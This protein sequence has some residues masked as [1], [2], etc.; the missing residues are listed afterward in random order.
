ML[1]ISSINI[2][3]LEESCITDSRP[4]IAFALES[5]REGES[6]K[7]ATISCEGW[8]LETSDQVNNHYGGSFE[9]FSTYTVQVVATGQSGD[10][11]EKTST[12]QTGRLDTPWQAKWITDGAYAI[13]DKQS[14]V[15]MVFR[16]CFAVGA[17]VRRARLFTTALG[18]Y[19]LCLN[20]SKVGQ[21]YF[22]PGLTSYE[23]QIQYQIYDVTKQ[24]LVSN[25]L[26]ATVAGGWAVGSFTYNRKNKISADRQALLLE[27][28]IEY[29]N[30][31]Q[32]IISTD[33]SWQVTQEGPYRIAEWY[34]GETFD[35]RIDL[36]QVE[37]KSASVTYPRGNP[38][39]IA[40]YGCPV[41]VQQVM[42]PVAH[43]KA[44]SGEWVYDFGQNFAGVISAK[45]RAQD[46]Q[47]L[48]F[49]HAEVLVNDELFIKSLRTAKATATYICKNGAQSY[50]PRLTY[51]GFRYVG[52]SGIKPEYIELEAFALHSELEETGSFE[53]SN[54]LINQLQSNI[55]WGGKSNFVD[56]PTDCPQR[57][58]RQG[59]TGDIAVFAQTACYN[60][61]MSRFFTKWLLD[62]Q[63]EQ[64]KGGGIPM[65]IPKAGDNWPV[66]ASACWG[67]SCVLVPWAEY[68]ARGDKSLLE[69]QY[70]VI[71]KFLK[72][73]KWW[74]SFMS[75]TPS[76]RYIWRWPFQYGDWCAPE[77]KVQQW[78]KR[79]KWIATPYFANSCAIAAQIADLLG[80]TEDA[81]YYRALQEKIIKA[82]RKVFTNGKGKLKKEFQT[83][84][85][86]PLYFDMA[87]GEERKAMAEN[88]ARL[89]RE[90]KNH[91]A[92][93]F[94]GTPYIL[95]ALSDNGHE[96]EA[97]DLLLQEG[98]PSWLYEVKA[99]GTTIWE[100]WDALREDGTVNITDLAKD[101]P[102][103][104]SDGGMVSF[105]HYAGGAVGDWLY[106]R[107]AGIEP[108]E[109]GYKTFRVA[110]LPGGGITSAKGCVRTPY[111]EILSDWNIRDGTFA[112]RVHVPVSAQCRLVLPNGEQHQLNSGK[113]SFSCDYAP[114]HSGVFERRKNR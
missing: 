79:G 98:C 61:D 47:R 54:P 70:P 41:R 74:A 43:F 108:I 86:L 10:V 6:L 24:L 52:V 76:G 80:K 51:M 38:R 84:Y 12:F 87:E 27:L 18:V 42:R 58:E 59:W 63:A 64:G 1:T 88:L 83:A 62:M 50:S 101:K 7:T 4:R 91:L 25:T 114:T 72:A 2:D 95:F 14:P 113:H 5:D 89:V 30:G 55:R 112:I 56:I 46:G 65:V 81:A 22:A 90:N 66:F 45:L 104:E 68:M 106:R 9:A 31:T 94:P 99:G 49:R 11:A 109:G 111:G 8:K 77:G 85:V 15:P 21:D 53:C 19:E 73:V 40:Q 97:F 105:N 37:W 39:L 36:E 75:I 110:P 20:G 32:E 69:R 3:G 33:E 78:I 28:H 82:F 26:T 29:E 57:D 17:P 100:R 107:L 67:D 92:T 23:N 93:G 96:K 13:T 102:E 103:A 71:Q 60:F 35:S 16:R 34:D 48:V 44:P